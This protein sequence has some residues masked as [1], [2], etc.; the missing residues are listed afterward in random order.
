MG[1]LNIVEFDQIFEACAPNGPP[2]ASQN[3]TTNVSTSA[4]IASA[5]DSD[6]KLVRLRADEAMYI[7]FG[8]APVAAAGNLVLDANQAEYIALEGGTLKIAGLDVA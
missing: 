5:L 4:A 7:D 3:L 1:T 2:I 8:T 6:T